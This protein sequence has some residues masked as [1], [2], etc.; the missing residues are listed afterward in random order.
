MPGLQLPIRLI[1]D[2][3]HASL[4]KY[5]HRSPI[6]MS[7]ASEILLS[8]LLAVPVVFGA[9]QDAARLLSIDAHDIP[10]WH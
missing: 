7:K 3:A 6:S 8:E 5:I 2:V 9:L 10:K 1:G 4:S